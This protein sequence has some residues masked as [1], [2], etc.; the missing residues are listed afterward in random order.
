MSHYDDV[1]RLQDELQSSRLHCRRLIRELELLRAQLLD[2]DEE[3]E[4]L[5][6]GR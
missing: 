3:I 4:A 5:K 2:A 1:A 6:A